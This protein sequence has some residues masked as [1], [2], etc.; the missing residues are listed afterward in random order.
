MNYRQSVRTRA[1]S[2]T[3]VK[4]YLIDISCSQIFLSERLVQFRQNPGVLHHS[5]HHDLTEEFFWTRI[6]KNWSIKEFQNYSRFRGNEKNG[7]RYET[8]FGYSIFISFKQNTNCTRNFQFNFLNNEQNGH[9]IRRSKILILILKPNCS[10]REYEASWR[11]W[12]SW[13]FEPYL[14]R[15]EILNIGLS[16]SVSKI[17][18]LY[19][20]WLPIKY[21]KK[22]AILNSFLW[23]CWR[24]ESSNFHPNWGEKI[25]HWSSST[26]Q[27]FHRLINLFSNLIIECSCS[28][29]CMRQNDQ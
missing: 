3:N 9:I 17:H 15:S 14:I 7:S 27:I 21:D 24:E 8:K 29:S 12:K 19:S 13:R 10:F 11:R 5:F 16:L 28:K 25:A 26:S 1:S 2:L 20:S 18:F 23:R 4:K 6:M 22:C